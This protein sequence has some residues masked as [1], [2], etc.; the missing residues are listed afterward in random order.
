[1]S[2]VPKQRPARSVALSET[3][4]KPAAKAPRKRRSASGGE[5]HR[6]IA[7]AAYYRA[8]RR[9]FAGG[10]PVNDWLEAE[11]EIDHNQA[12]GSRRKA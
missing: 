1:M 4:A 8:E 2:P 5:R 12:T 11:S 10:D 7:E 9:G 6:R 3:G